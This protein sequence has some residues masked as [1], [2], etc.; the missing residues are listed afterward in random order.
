MNL[1]KD[2]RVLTGGETPALRWVD[3]TSATRRRYFYESRQIVQRCT[4]SP[5][6]EG[7]GG[8][9][10]W[11]KDSVPTVQGP[12]MNEKMAYP[13]VVAKKVKPRKRVIRKEQNKSE[14]SGRTILPSA[15]LFVANTTLLL[16]PKAFPVGRIFAKFQRTGELY[17]GRGR[18]ERES[19]RLIHRYF[20]VRAGIVAVGETKGKRRRLVTEWKTRQLA[21]MSHYV[22]VDVED[23]SGWSGE[24]GT[25]VRPVRRRTL[26]EGCN[27][28]LD[29]AIVVDLMERSKIDVAEVAK[30]EKRVEDKFGE[31]NKK[32]EVFYSGR[33]KPKAGRP[34]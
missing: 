25:E 23:P 7:D 29:Q 22:E 3:V 4:R 13:D 15:V 16:P 32:Q 20:E 24:R 19:F 26:A 12:L 18:T 17:V 34:Q 6:V 9:R 1:T 10:E 33:G 28:V 31:L 5:A 11:D 2:E 30:W 8:V 21:G 14:G 27:F